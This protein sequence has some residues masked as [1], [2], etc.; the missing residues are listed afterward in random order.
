[1]LGFYRRATSERSPASQERLKGG[2]LAIVVALTLSAVGAGVAGAA[3]VPAGRMSL[4]TF[5]PTVRF[6]AEDNTGCEAS[7]HQHEEGKKNV[8]CDQYQVVVTDAGSLPVEG[9]V[10]I[11]DTVPEGLEVRSTQSV[12]TGIKEGEGEALACETVGQTVTCTFGEALAPARRLNLW[13]DVTVSAGAQSGQLNTATATAP[14]SPQASEEQPDIVGSEQETFGPSAL[15]ALIAGVNGLPDTEAGAHPY[16]FTTRVDFRSAIRETPDLKELGVTTVRDVKDA[17]V[18]LPLGFL[19]DALSTPQCALTE[20]TREAEAPT[21]VEERGGCPADTQVGLVQAE[22]TSAASAKGPIYNLVPE[23]G[24]AAEFGFVDVLHNIHVIYSSVA[25]TP[26]GYTIRATATDL[27]QAKLTDFVVSFFGEPAVRQEEIAR[28]ERRKPT[29]VP[30]V[31][32]FTNPANCG[33]GELQTAVHVDSWLDPGRVNPDGSPDLSDPNWTSASTTQPAVTG[34]SL[35]RFEPEAFSLKP[36]TTQ[37][38]AASG[39]SFDLKVPQSEKPETLGTPPLRDATV[40]LPAGVVVNPAAA[41]GLGSCSSAQIGWLGGSVTN[42]NAA[43]PACPDA[44]KIGSVEVA[45]PLLASTLPGTIYLAAQNDNPTHSLLGGYIVIDDPVS[46]TLVKIAGRLE[47]DPSSGQITGVFDENPQLP[48]SD[49]KLHFFGGVRGELAT[50]ESCGSFTT[51]SD[52][53]PWSAP[54]SGPD[55]TPSS[56]FQVNGGCAPG[57]APAFMAGATSPQGGAYSPFTLS[58]SRQDSEQELSGLTVTLP[59]GLVGKLAGVGECSDA[60]LAAAA[61]NPS[62]AG[63]QASPECPASSRIGS[64]QAS[65]GVGSEPFTLGGTAYLTGPYR[66]APFGIAVVV[67]A[68]AGPFDLGNVVVRSRLSIDP[69]DAHVTVVSDAFPTV[70]DA[71]G[72]DGGVDGFPIRMRSVSITMDR[73]SFTLNPTSCAPASIGATLTS[74]AG[75]SAVVS[76]HFQVG[77]CASLAFKPSLAVTTAG[78]ASKANG[79]SLDVK[80][81]YPSGPV[82]AYANIRSVKVDLP[83]QL[84][85]RLTTLQKA[86]VA[87]VFEA[88]PADCP[89]ASDVGTATASTPL[90]D[91]PLVGPAYIVSHGGEAFP[92]LE[93]VLQGDNVT[94]VLDGSTRIKKGITSSTFKT[95]PDAPVSS[96]DLKLPAGKYSILSANVAQSAHYSLCGQ[97]L[98]MPTAITGQNGAVI[99]QTTKISVTGCPK[100]HKAKKTKKAKKRGRKGKKA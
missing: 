64:V 24:V 38:D 100:A 96:F 41:G 21:E 57:F 91:V 39:L 67:P 76:S 34:C 33:G 35:L 43:Q 61:G 32:F 27:P 66:G 94:L 14:E 99:K 11:T 58:F 63:E 18:D 7:V 31:P 9:P 86:C 47:T 83:K 23:H 93:I 84:P 70:I 53:M 4:H 48:F 74:T 85:S 16:E 62:G 81:L 22:P 29:A 1:M 69:S 65:A 12:Y 73:P 95:V 97:T 49:L 15:G 40:K 2:L 52:L 42:F 55:A 6:S 60:E 46:G 10:T 87:K 3:V 92:D 17:A 37:A 50:P 25:P 36:E 45:T 79:A 51:A 44:S 75:V 56:T 72:A 5:V 19:G 54:E 78:H 77:S 71:R 82:G 13:I 90:L 89:V 68:L 88:D 28:G 98:A 30:H 26:A 8:A 80:V 59:P 20:L